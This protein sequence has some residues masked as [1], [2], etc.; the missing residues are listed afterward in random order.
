M[1][2]LFLNQGYDTAY[3][4]KWH[5][6]AKK[7]VEACGFQK[8]G[9]LKSK[10]NDHLIAAPS[11]E[12]MIRKRNKPF[13][14]V[15]SFS[16]P[17]D[18]CQLARRD[19]IPSGPIGTPPA[20]ESCPP[21]PFNL[22]PPKNETDSMS[23]IRQSYHLKNTFPVGNFTP[24]DWRQF[25]WG[26]YRL[27]E[28]VDAEIGKILNKLRSSGLHKNTLVIF[29]SDHGDCAGAH[30]FN[31]KTV[32]Y[33]E[34]A[35]IPLIISYPGQKAPAKTNQLV[36]TGIDILPTMLDFC[37]IKPPK[38]LKGRSLKNIVLNKK[39]NKS[40]KYIVIQ[41]HATQ[42]RNVD[43]L[44]V[45]IQGRMVRSDNFK[46]CV[47]SHGNQREALFDM[48]NDIGETINLAVDPAHKKTIQEH[49]K[50]LQ[51]HAKKNGD[52]LVES[53]L[54]NNVGPVAF[55]KGVSKKKKK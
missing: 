11:I 2:T 45:K 48:K 34:S 22:V 30:R 10:G 38:G 18:V 6:N 24:D 4:G 51:E 8:T 9:V 5:L 41:N 46:Y 29:T 36:N 35:R 1:G 3:F 16:N 14:L 52:K 31:Q 23:M 40:Q 12:F 50:M 49:R 15:T 13:L 20:P 21:V 44:E 25:R 27:V 32:F 39:I 17:H 47:Y 26:Y 54:K 55:V 53:L 37:N 28:R 19:K 42:G 7:N 33:E 43:S